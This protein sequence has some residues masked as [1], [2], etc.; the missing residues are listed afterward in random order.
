[1]SCTSFVG[2][3]FGAGPN[4]IRPPLGPASIFFTPTSRYADAMARLGDQAESRTLDSKLSAFRLSQNHPWV[5][6]IHPLWDVE[7][8]VGLLKDAM[9]QLGPSV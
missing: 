2:S 8:P 7:S 6:I 9:D 4:T 1:M 3:T 5:L